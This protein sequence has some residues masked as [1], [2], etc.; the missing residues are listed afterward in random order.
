MTDLRVEPGRTQPRLYQ[1]GRGIAVEVVGRTVADWSPSGDGKESAES[2]EAGMV[3]V[4]G[5]ARGPLA[6]PARA[7]P[8]TTPPRSRAIGPFP[9]PVGSSRDLLSTSCRS[10]FAKARP[11]ANVRPIA[12]FELDRVSDPAGEKTQYLVAGARGPEGQPCDFT[13]LRVYTWNLRKSRYE[14]AF[15]END[16]CGALPV[17]IGK[18]PKNEP[19]F[20]FS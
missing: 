3:L 5:C 19:E 4:R 12:W 20:R 10:L 13:T 17:R 11:T 7:A 6:K 1:F 16:L 8:K 9:S 15:I 18:G 2:Q 14:T